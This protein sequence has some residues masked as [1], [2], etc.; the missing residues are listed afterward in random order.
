MNVRNVERARLLIVG[1]GPAGTGPLIYCANRG[2]L[3]EVLRAGVVVVDQKEGLC[4]GRLGDYLIGSNSSASSFIESLEHPH[5]EGIFATALASHAYRKLQ[6]D[7]WATAPLPDVA[8]LLELIGRDLAQAIATSC[9]SQFQSRSRVSAIRTLPHGGFE[10][11]LTTP[12]G[13]HCVTSDSVLLATGGHPRYDESVAR[14][15]VNALGRSGVSQQPT[16]SHSDSVLSGRS[17]PAIK[18][19]LSQSQGEAVVFGG[20]HSAFSVAALLAPYARQVS[21]VH[22]KPIKVFYPSVESAHEEGYYDFSEHDICPETK[23]VF[24]IAGLRGHARE[25]YRQVT[26]KG[27]RGNVR[28]IRSAGDEITDEIVWPRQGAIIFALGYHFSKVP[29]FD[30]DGRELELLGD[31]TGEY[32]DSMC[33]LLDSSGCSIPGAYAVG[34]ATGFRPTGK[35]GGEPSFSGRDNSVWLCQHLL[36]EI[37]AQ[38][39]LV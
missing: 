20:S 8:Q 22:R 10:S 12:V 29:M 30:S 14:Q 2:L 21:I 32:V 19:R 5:S 28:L 3:H 37:L 27:Y 24:R 26:A 4:V 15:V 33:R 16:F 38:A 6:E 17:L 34:M 35:L 9:N 18:A 31:Y 36:G 1:G 13:E 7:R 11:T 39:T 23:R 25:L